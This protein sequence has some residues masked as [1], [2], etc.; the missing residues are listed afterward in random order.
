M[1]T[2]SDSGLPVFSGKSWEDHV[3][4]WFDTG[5]IMESALWMR[6]AIVASLDAKYGDEHGR[7][8]PEDLRDRGPP[9]PSPQGSPLPT[10]SQEPR[11]ALESVPP[12]LWPASHQ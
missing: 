7:R 3:S 12:S 4:S 9:L 11:L 6:G 5:E 8:A 2:K 10:H 1:K